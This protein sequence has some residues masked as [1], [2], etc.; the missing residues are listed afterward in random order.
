MFCS[1]CN[2]S[3]FGAYFI[4][5]VIP[6]QN[7]KWTTLGK[8]IT[9]PVIKYTRHNTEQNESTCRTFNLFSHNFL[10]FPSLSI[11]PHVTNKTGKKCIQSCQHGTKITSYSGICNWGGLGFWMRRKERNIINK[12]VDEFLSRQFKKMYCWMWL[13]FCNWLYRFDRFK[14]S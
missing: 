4:L 3:T 2:I 7:K 6:S 1:V 11:I 8:P 9:N 13:F 12:Y 10:R 5:P 14:E